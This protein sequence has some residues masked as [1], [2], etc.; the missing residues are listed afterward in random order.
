MRGDLERRAHQL[1]VAHATRF[2]G[3]H[4]GS[5]LID[6][7]KACDVVCLPSR[8]EPFG[9]SAL[10]GWAAGK[11][12]VA[13]Q[14]GGPSEFI[15]HDVTGLK[16]YATPDSV[17]WGLGTLFTNFEWAR[18]MGSNGRHAAETTFSWDSIAQKT[19]QCYQS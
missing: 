10:E 13:S 16:I 12:V 19:E 1:G 11:P 17:G 6:L 15:W 8:N 7:Y 4:N 18:W 2:L 5:N 9:I 14:N 3:Y